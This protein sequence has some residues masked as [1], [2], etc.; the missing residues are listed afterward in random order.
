VIA[1][2]HAGVVNALRLNDVQQR[3]EGL[4]F[5]S[6]GNTPDEFGRFIRA[7]IARWAKLIKSANVK[8]D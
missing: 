1:K 3:L 6:V 7:D 5:E 4:G 2:F 8:P